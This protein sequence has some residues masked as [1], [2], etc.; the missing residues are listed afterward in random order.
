MM[1]SQAIETIIDADDSS[2]VFAEK[3]WQ[4]D[5]NAIIDNLDGNYR[6]PQHI[7]DAGLEYFLESELIHELAEIKSEKNFSLEKLIELIIYYAEFDAYPDW[8]NELN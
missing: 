6:V 2:V 7:R 5:S 1:L 3:P 8:L 4:F